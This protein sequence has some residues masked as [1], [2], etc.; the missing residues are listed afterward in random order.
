MNLAFP[1][2]LLVAAL[3]PGIAFVNCYYAGKFPRELASLSTLAELAL[4][5]FWAVVIDSAV[6]YMF[7]EPLPRPGLEA[8]MRMA[9]GQPLNSELN[10]VY[11][12]LVSPNW[13]RIPA[14]YALTVV[15]AA[16]AGAILRR[17]V[18]TFRWDVYLPLFRMKSE[19]FYALQGR[20]SGVSRLKIPVADVLVEHPADGSRLYAGIVAGFES[21]EDGKIDQL[22]LVATQRH[23][24][25]GPATT[26]KDIPG[27]LFVIVGSTIHSINMRYEDAK[28]LGM[29]HP[30]SRWQNCLA[31]ARAMLRA[32]CFEEP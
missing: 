27:D 2:L 13:W 8:L 20:L 10:I 11:A 9:L 12:H 26:L 28:D 14:G 25:R 22:L 30:V 31:H 16:A 23:S 21:T 1:T 3:I 32:F 4:Y 24:G 15:L 29:T 18:W 17:I 5:C 7:V 6:L 19:W